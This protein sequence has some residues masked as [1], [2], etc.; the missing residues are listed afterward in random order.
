MKDLVVILIIISIIF[1]G[2]YLLNEHLTK[3][4]SEL[5]KVVNKMEES[6]DTSRNEKEKV[7]KTLLDIWEKH[8]KIHLSYSL[9]FQNKVNAVFGLSSLLYFKP[10]RFSTNLIMELSRLNV[11]HSSI[12]L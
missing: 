6:L 3:S 2:N 10:S 7:V 8:E 12:T 4:T 1:G 5:L 9:H 11:S